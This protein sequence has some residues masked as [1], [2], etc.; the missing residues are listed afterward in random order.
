MTESTADVFS[1]L[2]E[3]VAFP[4]GSGSEVGSAVFVTRIEL[5]TFVIV[6]RRV[7]VARDRVAVVVGARRRHDSL[8]EL[9]AL[10]V[11][12]PVKAQS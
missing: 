7:V 12:A 4:P 10:P 8:C 11:T 9:P 1:T 6:S 2:T 5:A 3:K